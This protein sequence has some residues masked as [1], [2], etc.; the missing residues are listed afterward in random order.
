[1]IRRLILW[2]LRDDLA[3]E[4]RLL[5][6]EEEWR[7]LLGK[8]AAAAA[9]EAKAQKRALRKATE[10]QTHLAAPPTLPKDRKAL[11]RQRAA[12]VRGLRVMGGGTVPEAEDVASDQDQ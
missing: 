9:R 4:K 3:T 2:I 8:M 10:A 11:L 7:D 12:S 5:E 1:M 6:I